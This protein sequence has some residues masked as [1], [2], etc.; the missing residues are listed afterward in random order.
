MQFIDGAV[1]FPE[2][3]VLAVADLHLGYE[4]EMRQKGV[5][6]PSGEFEVLFK[7]LS[8]I[9][10]HAKPEIVIVNGD[11][12]HSFG[13]ISDSE[14]RYAKRTLEL[15]AKNRQVVL[16]VGNHDPVLFPI[17][18][19][20]GVTLTEEFLVDQTLFVHGDKLPVSTAAYERIVI[21]HEH[22]AISISDGVRS[23]LVK[24]YLVGT[25]QKKQLVVLPSMFSLTEG[26]DV[27]SGKFLSPFLSDVSK[28][29]V[30]ALVD[31]KAL[32]FG[33]VHDV[34]RLGKK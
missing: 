1:Y 27:L 24:C 22:P 28:F 18:E 15:L 29:S 3:K 19:K 32:A 9:L 30:H 14:W 11:F 23:E 8:R 34:E 31:S 6:I 25:W 7:R 10:A 4:A 20:F 17:A 2:S 16:V 13:R 12:K 33:T 26:T 21:G 5:Q